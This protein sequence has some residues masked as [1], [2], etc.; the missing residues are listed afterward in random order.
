MD[1]NSIIYAALGAGAG[2][3]IGTLIGGAI[4]KMKSGKSSLAVIPAILC[5]AGYQLT[6]SLYKNMTLPRFFKAEITAL[7][8]EWPLMAHIRKTDKELYDSLVYPLDKMVRN[9]AITQDGLNAFR[10]KYTAAIDAKRNSASPDQIR[11]ENAVAN[12]IL[13]VLKDKSPHTCTQKFHGRPYA[14]LEAF[15]D[16]NLAKREQ[17]VIASFFY[18]P[19]QN[20]RQNP[21]TKNGKQIFEALIKKKVAEFDLQDADP[22]ILPSGENRALHEKICD[23]QISLNNNVNALGDEDFTDVLSYIATLR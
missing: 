6:V 9:G 14:N 18:N 15:I 1:Y 16:D 11:E 10:E 4:A 13:S 5:L 2:A 23:F 7:E 3:G 12:A 20:G 8:K 22:G 21:D 19:S 17:E